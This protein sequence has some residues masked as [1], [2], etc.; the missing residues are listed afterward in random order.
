MIA[1]WQNCV[2][3]ARN[4][5]VQ[6]W[7]W[8]TPPHSFYPSRCL[9][10]RCVHRCKTRHFVFMEFSGFEADVNFQIQSFP[11]LWYILAGPEWTCVNLTSE[12]K[13]VKP[14]ILFCFILALVSLLFIFNIVSYPQSRVWKAGHLSVLTNTSTRTLDS[15]GPTCSKLICVCFI[16]L[17][18]ML[19]CCLV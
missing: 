18:K 1:L 12:A 5:E 11:M 13:I 8:W 17:K 10:Q 4:A 6:S 3:V 16:L 14:C 9:S 15:V 2:A 7:M 19:F